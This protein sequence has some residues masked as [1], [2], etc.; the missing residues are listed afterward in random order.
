[1]RRAARAPA[2]APRPRF[3]EEVLIVDGVTR[4]GKF[5]LSCVLSAFDR[6]E[7]VQAAPLLTSL[8]YLHRL[9]NI[10]RETALALLRV[11]I[12]HR[13]HD[14]A[15][16]RNLNSRYTD[17]SSVHRAPGAKRYLARAAAPDEAAL[18]ARFVAERRLPQFI[19]HD[20]LCHAGLVFDAL[21]AARMIHM[22]RDPVVL[23][24][25]WLKR[26]W[27]RRFGTDP[28]SMDHAFVS[29]RGPIP[30]YATAWKTNY[31]DLGEVDRIVRSLETAIRLAKAGWRS[32]PAR[33]RAKVAFVSFE[34]LCADPR[35]TV[36]RL[37]G[38]LDAKPGPG[39]AGAL[40]RERLPRE[41]DPGA[42]E[43][44][45]NRFSKELSRDSFA[46]LR[47]MAADYDAF[48]RPLAR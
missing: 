22:L 38:F 1:V 42:R 36:W 3:V 34:D 17:L 26:G 4:S 2:I 37:A 43:V 18:L 12:A 23:V 45:L 28:R 8:P 25:S 27:G 15:L 47:R 19:G 40:K 20:A 39:L 29:S 30:W 11:E 6:V 32:L 44:L 9:G 13:V 16:G 14:R 41:L 31:H 24:Q 5:L 48:W 46:R 33:R 10:G 7:F 35:P 21:P